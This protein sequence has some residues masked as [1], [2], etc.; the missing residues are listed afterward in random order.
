MQKVQKQNVTKK[1]LWFDMYKQ[2]LFEKKTFYYIQYR[3]KNNPLSTDTLQVNKIALNN[4]DN[5]GI[6]TFCYGGNAFMVFHEELIIKN[7]LANYLDKLK[8][9]K[10]P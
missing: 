3:I 8:T 7:A 6:T 10:S 2:C 9:N 1:T 4:Y 5:N